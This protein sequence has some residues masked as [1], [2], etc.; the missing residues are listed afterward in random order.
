MGAQKNRLMK[1]IICVP[2]V[3]LLVENLAFVFEF[4]QKTPQ[5]NGILSTHDICFLVKK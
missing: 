1:T 5:W 4:S 2:N 3:Y